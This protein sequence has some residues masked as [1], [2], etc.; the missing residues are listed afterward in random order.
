MK[1]RAL[2]VVIVCLLGCASQPMPRNSFDEKVQTKKARTTYVVENLC[3]HPVDIFITTISQKNKPA[4]NFGVTKGKLLGL[5]L[6]SELSHMS[7]IKDFTVPANGRVTV[8]QASQTYT[9]AQKL[10]WFKKFR[11]SPVAGVVMNDPYDSVQWHRARRNNAVTYT[12]FACQ[13]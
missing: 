3:N 7:T 6:S 2:M 4:I 1:N 12:F 8:K 13:P 5:S 11:I 10:S 9:E